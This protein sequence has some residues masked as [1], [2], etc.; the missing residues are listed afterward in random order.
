MVSALPPAPE[1]QVDDGGGGTVDAPGSH[2][3]ATASTTNAAHASRDGWT[4]GAVKRRLW[5]RAPIAS[6]PQ[7][8]QVCQ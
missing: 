1:V 6:G 3:M 4:G 2:P 8:S 7:S 5:A